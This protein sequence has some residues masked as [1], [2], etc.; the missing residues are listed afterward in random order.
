MGQCDVATL[1]KLLATLMA[2]AD[3]E[4][5]NLQASS[6]ERHTMEPPFRLG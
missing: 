3:Q 6:M 1:T 4:T 5:A 2:A